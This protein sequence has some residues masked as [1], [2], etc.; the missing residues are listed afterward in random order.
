MLLAEQCAALNMLL[1]L[2]LLLLLTRHSWP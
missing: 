2:L 1:L